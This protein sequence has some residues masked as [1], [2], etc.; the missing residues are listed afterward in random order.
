MDGTTAR[1][2]VVLRVI[3][4]EQSYLQKMVLVEE[5]KF[6]RRK[7]WMAPVLGIKWC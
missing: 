7:P 4:S 1:E 2:K 5:E 3:C 6:Y